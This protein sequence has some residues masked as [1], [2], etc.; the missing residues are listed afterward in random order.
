MMRPLSL[1]SATAPHSTSGPSAM[2]WTRSRPG[3]TATCGSSMG[4]ISPSAT[5]PAS[6]WLPSQ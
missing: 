4:G 5:K 1:H 6:A 2:G 3:G